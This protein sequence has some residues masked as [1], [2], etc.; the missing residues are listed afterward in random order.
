MSDQRLA[1]NA[2]GPRPRLLTG[3]TVSYKAGAVHLLLQDL[4]M[5]VRNACRCDAADNPSTEGHHTSCAPGDAPQ[6]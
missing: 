6:D 5:N 3:C 2:A 4:N 1:A